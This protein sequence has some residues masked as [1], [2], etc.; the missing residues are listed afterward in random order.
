[1]R[2]KRT[3][4]MIVTMWKFDSNPIMC[5]QVRILADHKYDIEDE[6]MM[7]T[8][9]TMRWVSRELFSSSSLRLL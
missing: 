8:T 7:T 5:E 4:Q 2:S 1:M 3:R 6:E 9:T